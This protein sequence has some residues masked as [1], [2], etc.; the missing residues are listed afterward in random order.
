AAGQSAGSQGMSVRGLRVVIEQAAGH[1]EMLGDPLGDIA[2]Q[3]TQVCPHGTIQ[4][5]TGDSGRYRRLVTGRTVGLRL[6]RSSD[7]GRPCSTPPPFFGRPLPGLPS[8]LITPTRSPGL[9]P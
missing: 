8:G 6:R 2:S 1:D 5:A 3:A 4:L 7:A 9:V